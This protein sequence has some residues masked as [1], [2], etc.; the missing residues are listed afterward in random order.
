MFF[1]LVLLLVDAVI[2]LKRAKAASVLS[3]HHF[4]L[5]PPPLILYHKSTTSNHEALRV[6]FLIKCLSFATSARQLRWISSIEQSFS[7]LKR[8]NEE[9]ASILFGIYYSDQVHT[10]QSFVRLCVHSLSLDIF[11]KTEDINRSLF[12]IDIRIS[13]TSGIRSGSLNQRKKVY[14]EGV[15]LFV[16]C[17]QFWSCRF[18]CFQLQ[19]RKWTK[20]SFRDSDEHHVRIT[21]WFV[22]I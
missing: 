22:R 5:T 2:Y 20:P 19:I 6:F 15:C 13:I 10:R 12:E 4:M 8:R 3:L 14:L 9:F 18:L 17:S 7:G 11:D 21:E 1:I 16:S